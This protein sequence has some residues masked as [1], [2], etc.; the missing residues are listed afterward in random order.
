MTP[1][2]RTEILSNPHKRAQLIRHVR[3]VRAAFI[4]LLAQEARAQNGETSDFPGAASLQVTCDDDV[5]FGDDCEE[6][7]AFLREDACGVGDEFATEGYDNCTHQDP[8]DAIAAASIFELSRR[9]QWSTVQSPVTAVIPQLTAAEENGSHVSHG[10]EQ[11]NESDS[12]LI[13]AA[14]RVLSSRK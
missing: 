12:E 4:D 14:S 8:A 3:A 6:E 5:E 7:V 2:R 13:D 10:N 1:Q 9:Q 11:V